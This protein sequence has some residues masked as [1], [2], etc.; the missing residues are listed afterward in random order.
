MTS[1]VFGE[2]G[3]V[4]EE[5]L[6]IFDQARGVPAERQLPQSNTNLLIKSK[7]INRLSAGTPPPLKKPGLVL[8]YWDQL[9]TA[10][11]KFVRS[12]QRAE[13]VKEVLRLQAFC[14][15]AFPSAK[16]LAAKAQA[17]EKTW[18]RCIDFLRRQGWARTF[19]LVRPDGRQSV[20]LIDLGKLWDLLSAI[21]SSGHWKIQVL[22]R[23][24]WVKL[25]GMWISLSSLEE[26]TYKKDSSSSPGGGGGPERRLTW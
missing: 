22:K 18:D 16:Y 19:R 8:K 21:L 1:L 2:D 14:R 26:M 4:W 12:P 7:D 15:A 17:S 25:S 10:L 13:M 20:N 6:P 9:Y 3:S 24:V 5:N 23:R 11:V